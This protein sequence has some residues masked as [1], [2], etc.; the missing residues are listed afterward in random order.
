MHPG[1]HLVRPT[2]SKVATTQP[3][4]DKNNLIFAPTNNDAKT[5]SQQS[6][7]NID[8]DEIFE[9]IPSKQQ[10]TIVEVFSPKETIEEEKV[11]MRLEE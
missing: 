6:D 2:N 4:S 5:D 11:F 1:Q 3:N 7:R 8:E 9:E 10:R